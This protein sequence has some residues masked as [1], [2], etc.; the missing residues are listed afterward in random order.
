MKILIIDTEDGQGVSFGKRCTEAG[1]SV[2]LF[3]KPHPDGSRQTAGDGYVP[4]V[5]DYHPH[6]K[7]ADLIVPT[8]NASFM[9]ERDAL[10]S[11]GFPI[12]AGG[13]LGVKLEIDRAFA[14]KLLERK[15]L[16]MIPYYEFKDLTEAQDFIHKHGGMYVVKTV[17]SES[18]KSLTH[19]PSRIE[20]AEQEMIAMFDKWK[21]QGKMKGKI[22]L[23]EFW[24]GIEVGISCYFGPGGW[25]QWKNINFEFKKL[26]SRNFGPATGEMATC[27]QFVKKSR[28]FDEL[29]EPITEY[30]HATNYV[31]DIAANSIVNDKGKIGFLE[32]TARCGWPFEHGVQ[33]LIKG[34]PA[35]WKIDMI[36]GKDTMEVYPDACTMLVMGQPNFP[37]TAHKNKDAENIPIFGITPENQ[38]HLHY[39]DVK[40]GRGPIL[41]NGNIEYGEMPVTSGEYVMVIS[42]KAKTINESAKKAYEIAE[43]IGLPNKICRDDA[44]EKLEKQL[45][46]LHKHGIATEIN[47]E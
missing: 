21:K 40:V 38:K 13:T 37:Y 28:L 45:P 8:G 46:K 12:F 33:E 44:G 17:G 42:E 23:Q 43:F 16:E 41:K 9:A 36:N 14:M 30:L 5:N 31:G 39:V 22:M 29:L 10:V 6:L 15:G 7:D 34:D 2:K 4:K 32:Y 27:I 25:G 3:I 26:C 47:F 18:D 20:Y 1:H 24:P 35:Q 11:E 19:V